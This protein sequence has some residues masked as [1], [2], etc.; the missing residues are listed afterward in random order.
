MAGLSGLALSLAA[1][2][3]GMV[4]H[5]EQMA[6]GEAAGALDRTALL[7]HADDPAPTL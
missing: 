2:P 6:A 1:H 4:Y 5:F 3:D 7:L